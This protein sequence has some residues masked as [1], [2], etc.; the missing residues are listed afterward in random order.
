MAERD[1]NVEYHDGGE[2]PDCVGQ[3]CCGC[4]EHPAGKPWGWNWTA[5]EIHLAAVHGPQTTTA[6]APMDAAADS[7]KG[8]R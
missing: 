3:W 5:W 4:A 8:R 6:S 7:R 1:P 2:T